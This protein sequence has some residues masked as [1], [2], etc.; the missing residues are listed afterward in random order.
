MVK[1]KEKKNRN[2][3]FFFSVLIHPHILLLFL[4]SLNGGYYVPPV[5]VSAELEIPD[6]LPCASGLYEWC[7]LSVHF[8]VF[9]RTISGSTLKSKVDIPASRS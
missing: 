5:F 6:A 1:K 8:Q 4:F 2:N 9:F 7:M 3:Q